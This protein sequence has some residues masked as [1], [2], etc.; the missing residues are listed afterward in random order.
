MDITWKLLKESGKMK[1][2]EV[3]IRKLALRKP[4]GGEQNVPL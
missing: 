2:H 1:V 4:K 3:C